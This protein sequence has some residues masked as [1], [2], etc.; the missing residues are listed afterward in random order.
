MTSWKICT[1]WEYE[2]A[3]PDCHRLKTMVKRSIEQNLRM[4]SFEARNGN[5]ETSAVVKNQ[6]VK[7]RE[8]RSLRDCWQWNADGQCSK[9]DNCSFRHD[10][11][12]RAKSTQ[13]NLSP[14][15]STQQN[16]KNAP[17]T[18]SPRARSPCGKMARLPCKDYLKG[19]CTTPF[20]EKWHPPERLFYRSEN[21]CKFEDKCSYANRQVDEQ[22]SKN[23]KKNGY[24]VAVAFVKNTRHLGCVFQDMEPPK[25]SSILRKSSN[26]LK[27][28]RC[29][30]FT[31]SVFRHANI[32]DQKPSLGIYLPR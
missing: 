13:P 25:S 16:V 5:V 19:T 10:K 20:C 1:N 32:R 31:K 30:Q 24:R 6:R 21:G 28:I 22:P 9:G 23:S 15:S 12:Q 7:Q 8:Q 2:R 29:V 4:K 3:E 11:D 26:I 27:P 14:R 17:R 18:K